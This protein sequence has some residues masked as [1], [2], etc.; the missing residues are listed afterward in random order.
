MLQSFRND[1]KEM[2]ED[3]IET[4]IYVILLSYCETKRDVRRCKEGNG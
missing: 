4:I 3:E 1:N 2:L